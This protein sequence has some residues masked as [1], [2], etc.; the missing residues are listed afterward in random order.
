MNISQ[1]AAMKVTDFLSHSTY[2]G[3]Y[4][5]QILSHY[6]ILLMAPARSA[7]PGC[8]EVVSADYRFK[9]LSKLL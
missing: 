3:G 6:E 2:C 5:R 9:T 4:Q 8:I 7:F 1:D